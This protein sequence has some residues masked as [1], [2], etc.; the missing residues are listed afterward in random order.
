MHIFFTPRV[1]VSVSNST[2]VH[3]ILSKARQLRTSGQY[4][5]VFIS[6]DRSADQRAQQKELIIEL[7]KRALEEPNKRHF[8][9]GGEVHTVDKPSNG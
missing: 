5:K 9:R 7:K 2:I 1:K 3:Q 4:S 6:P 8:I